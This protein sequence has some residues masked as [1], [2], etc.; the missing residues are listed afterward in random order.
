MNFRAYCWIFRVHCGISGVIAENSKVI[1]EIPR[2]IA[3]NSGYIAEFLV[4][5][6]ENFSVI[7][8]FPV[9]IAEIFSM[10]AEKFRVHRV[11]TLIQSVI[12]IEARIQIYYY[13]QRPPN[14]NVWT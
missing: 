14:V 9:C 13:W 11:N 3:E 10:I 12:W 2:M 1:A 5:I 7:A 4:Y 6:A 8:E